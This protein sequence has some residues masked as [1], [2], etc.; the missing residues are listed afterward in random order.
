M[1][2]IASTYPQCELTFNL[3]DYEKK[4][5][6]TV[7]FCACGA[8]QSLIEGRTLKLAQH[9]NHASTVAVRSTQS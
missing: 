3:D 6:L 1:L 5:S 9:E 7:Q 4:E 8:R 2:R